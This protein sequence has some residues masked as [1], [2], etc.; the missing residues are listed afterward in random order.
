MVEPSSLASLVASQTALEALVEELRP[1]PVLA[2]DSESNSF[3][4]YRERVCLLQISTRRHD[5]IVDPFSVDPRPLGAILCDGREMVLHGADYDVRCLRREYGWRF[6][7]LFDTMIAARRLGR[8]GLGLAALVETRFGVRLSKSFQRSDWGRR[9]LGDEQLKYASLDTHFL[10]DLFDE[11]KEGL[12]RSGQF[13]AARREFERISLAEPRERS[14][15]PEG[16]RR[17]RGAGQLQPAGRSVLRSLWI[18]RENKARALDRPPFKVLGDEAMLEVARNLPRTS[19]ELGQ[20]RGVT[21]HLLRKLGEEILKSVAEAAG[22]I[23]T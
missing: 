23:S 13:E 7:C 1:E 11:L 4:V 22:G 3:H 16:W 2:L 8:P 5:F 21:P 19:A 15:D 20:M 6:P 17:M 9:P 18:F 14:F 10:L 12:E